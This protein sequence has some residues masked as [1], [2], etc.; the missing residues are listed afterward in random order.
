MK[1]GCE[2]LRERQDQRRREPAVSQLYPVQVGKKLPPCA[3]CRHPFLVPLLQ[4]EMVCDG[5]ACQ[6]VL[7]GMIMMPPPAI[8]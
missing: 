3:L 4:S 2:G 1:L 8:I 7:Y 5:D 6:R